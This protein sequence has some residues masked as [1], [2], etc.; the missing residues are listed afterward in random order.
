MSMIISLKMRPET[1]L[2]QEK[3]WLSHK[4]MAISLTVSD[5]ACHLHVFFLRTSVHCSSVSCTRFPQAMVA[6]LCQ[7]L[8]RAV[9]RLQSTPT[10]S[11]Y[12]LLLGTSCQGYPLVSCPVSLLPSVL[13]LWELFIN[14]PLTNPVSG[15]V[16]H[17][18]GT[19]LLLMTIMK[20][21]PHWS[22][23]GGKTNVPEWW[24]IQN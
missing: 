11:H 9:K 22:V 2:S 16:R 5:S 10:E 23:M 4:Q 12:S 1:A 18:S 17:M 15:F 24:E 14:K 13:F 3:L 7:K 6:Q 20:Q 19:V 8:E 21:E